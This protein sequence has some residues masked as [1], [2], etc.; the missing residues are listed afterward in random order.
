MKSQSVT[1]QMKAA[2]PVVL[3][4]IVYE[5]VRTLIPY[6]YM[7]ILYNVIIFLCKDIEQKFL[8]SS[9]EV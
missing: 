5:V 9:H 3:F 8:F 7:Y 2:F 1:I 4:V 6:T